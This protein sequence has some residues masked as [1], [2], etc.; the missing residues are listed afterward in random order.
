MHNKANGNESSLIRTSEGKGP[1]GRKKFKVN[2]FISVEAG[3]RQ[4]VFDGLRRT[5]T[6]EFIKQLF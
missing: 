6:L 3:T 5:V 2:K 1:T 4:N